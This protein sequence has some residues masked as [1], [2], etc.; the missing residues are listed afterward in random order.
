MVRPPPAATALTIDAGAFRA[1]RIPIRTPAVAAMDTGRRAP[2]RAGGIGLREERE[3]DQRQI[4]QVAHPPAGPGTPERAGH[5]DHP[6]GCAPSSP[7][8]SALRC[9]KRGGH[10]ESALRL[11]V[12]NS[13]VAQHG[14]VH[15][16]GPNQ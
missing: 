13:S 2:E 5:H 10:P 1:A 3:V 15:Q 14:T 12:L 8:S 4:R 16:K 7:C 11:D 9:C 6:G